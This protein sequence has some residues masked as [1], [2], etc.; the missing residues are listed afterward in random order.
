MS[1]ARMSQAVT[2]APDRSPRIIARVAHRVWVLSSPA[3][4]HIPTMKPTAHRQAASPAPFLCRTS[5]QRPWVLRRTSPARAGVP[6]FSTPP[7]YRSPAPHSK[8]RRL[9]RSSSLPHRS[10]PPNQSPL[11]DSAAATAP[12]RR[13]RLLLLLQKSGYHRFAP[14][15]FCHTNPDQI[16]T[17]RAAAPRR[18]AGGERQF[19][20]HGRSGPGLLEAGLN[21]LSFAESRQVG[22]TG[23]N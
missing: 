3:V 14:P 1:S 8:A 6:C 7:S 12:V 13:A 10:Y 20:Y 18:V 15:N 2:F 22:S 17:P 19:N 4:S 11:L 5:A 21:V 16:V 23:K 9:R